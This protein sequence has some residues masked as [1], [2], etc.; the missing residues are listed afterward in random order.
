VAIGGCTYCDVAIWPTQW[1]RDRLLDT[2]A[3]TRNGIGWTHIEHFR[4]SVLLFFSFLN[5]RLRF[6]VLVSMTTL[7]KNTW[8]LWD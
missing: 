8:E 1:N 7:G 2:T 4:C 6:C 3:H 5:R